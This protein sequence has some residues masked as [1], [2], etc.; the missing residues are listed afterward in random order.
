V[1]AT[2]QPETLGA[3][4][5]RVVARLNRW[6]TR[7]AAFDVPPARARLLGLIDDIG[8][9]R[10]RAL[11]AADHCSQPTMSVQVQHLEADG[12]VERVSDPKDAR[13]SLVSISAAGRRTLD[14]VRRARVDVVAPFLVDLPEHTL[15]RLED[16]VD[17]MA[18][19]LDVVSDDHPHPLSDSK[20]THP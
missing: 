13:A 16:A 4:L 10:I 7:H 2:T 9:A 14:D 3:D 5:L 11:A 18:D 12:W 17:A 20:D 19:L 15:R 6:A 1:T 8:P